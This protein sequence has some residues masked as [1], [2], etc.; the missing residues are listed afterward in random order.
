MNTLRIQTP[1]GIGFTLPLAGPAVRLFAW[2]LDFLI[3][4]V[5]WILFTTATTLAGFVAEELAQ[6]AMLIGWFVLPF[7]YSMFF[8]WRWRGQTP[9]KR[10]FR[11]R[12]VDA[13]G[14]RLQPG[15]VLLRNL[16]RA[17]DILPAFYVVGGTACFLSRRHQRLGDLA[18]NTVVVRSP[19]P[20]APALEAVLDD[21]VNSLRPMAHLAARLRQRVPA[22]EAALALQALLRRDDLEPGARV[23]LYAELA[24]HFRERVPYPAEIAEALADEQYLRNVVDILYRPRETPVPGGAG[25]DPAPESIPQPPAR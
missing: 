8:E 3:V 20:Q 21:R 23:A 2:G 5:V 9:G 12:V 10:V 22:D 15:Q 11:L 7:A 18:A 4:G 24:G 14:L 6:S 1:E 25:A 17:V 13:Q 16:L 19:R